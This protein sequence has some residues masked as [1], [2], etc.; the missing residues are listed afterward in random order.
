M[1]ASKTLPSSLPATVTELLRKGIISEEQISRC[2]A[3]QSEQ[4]EKGEANPEPL[5]NM[6]IRQGWVTEEQLQDAGGTVG[7][8]PSRSS[9]SSK[10]SKSKGAGFQKVRFAEGKEIFREGDPPPHA[11]FLLTK[12]EVRISKDDRELF[13]LRDPGTFVGESSALL[14]VPREFTATSLTSSTLF[15]L[16]SEKIDSFLQ[17]HPEMM[18]QLCQAM[19][20][21]MQELLPH[22]HSASPPAAPSSLE[23]SEANVTSQEI[24]KPLSVTESRDATALEFESEQTLEED[25]SPHE[26]MEEKPLEQETSSEESADGDPPS[27]TEGLTQEENTVQTMKDQAS[28][29]MPESPP[30]GRLSKESIHAET[31]DEGGTETS[32]P[33]EEQ[34]AEGKDKSETGLPEEMTPQAETDSKP[35]SSE[36]GEPP[37]QASKDG[38][39]KPKKLPPDFVMNATRKNDLPENIEEEDTGAVPPF[40]LIPEVTEEVIEQ[41]KERIE[42]CMEELT[43]CH[44]SQQ[45]SDAFQ[46][47]LDLLCELEEV[48]SQRL[49]LEQSEEEIDP[50]IKSEI[51]RQKSAV[52]YPI[53]ESGLKRMRKELEGYRKKAIDSELFQPIA[54][55]GEKQ[56]QLMEELLHKFKSILLACSASCNQEP[57]YQFFLKHSVQGASDLFGWTLYT[58]Q[59]DNH[60]QEAS[61]KKKEAKKEQK[62][63]SKQETASTKILK[64]VSKKSDPMNDKKEELKQSERKMS[65]MVSAI[66]MEKRR[67]EKAMVESFWEIYRQSAHLLVHRRFDPLDEPFL[68][69]FLRWGAIG[70]S[71]IFLDTEIAKQILMDC[72]RPHLSVEQELHGHNIYFSD[73][74]LDLIGHGL[75]P[76]SM[77][78]ELEL[79]QRNSPEWKVD[80]AWRRYIQ[81]QLYTPLVQQ[82]LVELQK[83]LEQQR[84]AVSGLNKVATSPTTGTKA[85]KAKKAQAGYELMGAKEKMGR[86]QVAVERIEHKLLPKLEFDQNRTR[87]VITKSPLR[88][89]QKEIINREVAT[90]QRYCRLVAKFTT[91]FLPLTLR[92]RFRPELNVP[93]TRETVIEE[94]EEGEKR[95]PLL[96]QESLFPAPK[97][98]SRVLMR[99]PPFIFLA[100]SM[101]SRGYMA[102]PRSNVDAGTLIMPGYFERVD[103]RRS[104][105]WELFADYRFESS[106]ANAGMDLLHSDT[107]VAAYMHFRW[108]W[109]NKQDDVRKKALLFMDEK[110]NINWRRHYYI[111]LDSAFESGSQLFFKC[112][113]LYDGLIDKYI[114]LPEGCE[115]LKRD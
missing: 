80:N 67:N 50:E 109:R 9:K 69:S 102:S 46:E 74:S 49:R 20:K 11:L 91:H 53:T 5:E 2:T 59:L 70:H 65:H 61:E 98:N 36:V 63:L 96:C 18:H 83:E 38:A 72:V 16:P 104:S 57:L 56:I 86:L 85:A 39:G 24:A 108:S 75:L 71:P 73:E 81:R 7:G 97:K 4:T 103:Q 58:I 113:D 40:S 87:D 44:I 17:S 76:Q 112:P 14:K 23:E 106:K 34:E 12:G 101:G 107:L 92:E 94:M 33:E 35:A 82:R 47:R 19:A 10:P 22:C 48:Q 99:Q 31:F 89:V 52:E 110:D 79:K 68:R 111:Y 45:A 64:I 30:N 13:I 51:R 114:D 100:P 8:S 90:L 95:D 62:S 93:N 6:L 105:M 41:R 78:E 88:M 66:R 27:Q 37:Q 3:M 115:I 32:S 1:N 42:N 77:S 84:E 29:S 55:F 28:T 26:E 54:E 60:L 25:L 21:E 15:R 43:K